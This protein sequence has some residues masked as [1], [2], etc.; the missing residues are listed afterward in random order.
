MN[1]PAIT[2]CS[3]LT[4]TLHNK[5]NYNDFTVKMGFYKRQSMKKV[6]YTKKEYQNATIDEQRI[7]IRL[8]YMQILDLLERNEIKAEELGMRM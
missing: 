2:V 3:G 5:Q 6:F 7:G 1:F 8:N 4:L